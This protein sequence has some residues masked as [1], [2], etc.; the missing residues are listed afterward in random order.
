MGPQQTWPPLGPRAALHEHAHA[1]GAS[2]V[3]KEGS[4]S[5]EDMCISDLVCDRSKS[6]ENDESDTGDNSSLESE[7]CSMT[8]CSCDNESDDESDNE[9]DDESDDE[10]D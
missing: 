5:D 9:S 1:E 6:D 4:D 2:S 7:S 10:S 8:S 3:G